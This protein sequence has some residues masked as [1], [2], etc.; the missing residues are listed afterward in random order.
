MPPR[1]AA[2]ELNALAFSR[3]SF[4]AKHRMA[5]WAKGA[6][7]YSSRMAPEIPLDAKPSYV[8]ASLELRGRKEN[9]CCGAGT[10]GVA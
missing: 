6:G 10:P 3:F 2:V 9:T 1:A 4:D 5:H 8:R 7:A